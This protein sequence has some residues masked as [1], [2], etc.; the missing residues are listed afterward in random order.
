MIGIVVGLFCVLIVA[1]LCAFFL[2]I[3]FIWYNRLIKPVFVPTSGYFSFMMC[4]VYFSNIAVVSRLVTGKHFFPSLLILS[5]IGVF[6]VLFVA[7]FFSLKLLVGGAV[8]MSV[9]FAL[10]FF[11]QVRFFIKEI[12]IALYYL[13]TFLFNCY[14][15]VVVFAIAL[16][17]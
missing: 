1:G 9:L 17:N 3:D 11:Q 8:V 5:A 4:I 7:V 10:S 14:A 15:F 6:S 12:R 2:K 13:P 16:T